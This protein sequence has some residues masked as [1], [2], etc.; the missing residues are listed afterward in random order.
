VA[1]QNLMPLSCGKYV[2]A[3]LL[4]PFSSMDV[5]AGSLR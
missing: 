4:L 3:C 5:N 1:E 2:I